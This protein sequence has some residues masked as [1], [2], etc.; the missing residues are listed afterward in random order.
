MAT[1]APPF[2]LDPL[3]AEAKQR[4]RRRR[5]LVLAAAGLIAAGLLAFELASSG[6]GGGALGT[7][8]WLPTKPS[9]PADPP[10]APPC[11][12]AQLH[13]SLTET[14]VNNRYAA[15]IH[16]MNRSSTACALVG[17]PS[18]A[19]DRWRVTP[20]HNAL[21]LTPN[22]DPLVPVGSLRAMH[23]GAHATIL[24]WI[25]GNC[26][27]GLGARSDYMSVLRLSAPGGGTI[28]F[29]RAT[30]ASCKSLANLPVRATRYMPDVRPGPPSSHLPLSARIVAPGLRRTNRVGVGTRP[31]FVRGYVAPKGKWLSY[32][33]VLTNRSK[34]VFR[35]GKTCPSYTEGIAHTV[36]YVLNCRPVG[37][38]GPGKSVR[39]AMRE[40]VPPHDP[41]VGSQSFAVS[42]VLSPHS[43]NPPVANWSIEVR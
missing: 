35:F 37:S 5:L 38:I 17:L 2:G 30:P 42:W 31:H 7:I 28:G 16:L 32:A 39:F 33:V 25:P 18:F 41:S 23:P 19:S 43:H 22:I 1:H 9:I 6:T 26:Q 14:G 27:I 40:R 4:A 8:P 11:T 24:V 13:S 36:A 29:R 3:I 34:Q 12:A 15:E 10:L 20:W 21:R